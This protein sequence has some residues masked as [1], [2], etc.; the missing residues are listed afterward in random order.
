VWLEVHPFRDDPEAPLWINLQK[1]VK[2]PVPLDYAGFRAI[3]RRARERYNRMAESKGLPV[4]PSLDLY[5]FRY[6][7]Q[8]RDELDGV[9]RSVQLRQ[10]GWKYTSRM[11][12]RYARLVSG[13][14]D[15]YY[16]KKLGLNGDE[17]KITPA[18]CPRCREINLPETRFCKRCGLP[19]T[20]EGMKHKEV[21]TRLALQILQD[22][23]L[24][25]E[26]LEALTFPAGASGKVSNER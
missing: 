13:D 23:E 20:D 14:V 17:D 15:E 19:L 1:S 9:P 4:L 7:A 18:P 10:R 16:R 24:R 21:V 11:P 5:G 25:Q 22:P 12:D 26:F 8:I 6:H 3:E 2:E